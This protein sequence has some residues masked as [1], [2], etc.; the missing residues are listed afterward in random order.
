MEH[1]GTPAWRSRMVRPC[2]ATGWPSTCAGPI[3][4]WR[5]A[6]R[7]M[8][9]SSCCSTSRLARWTAARPGTKHS[10]SAARL[11]DLE[12][13]LEDASDSVRVSFDAEALARAIDPDIEAHGLREKMA[14]LAI[15]VATTGAAAGS[16]QAMPSLGGQGG[17]SGDATVTSARD[18]PAD[19]LERVGRVHRGRSR[20]PGKPERC[21]QRRRIAPEDGGALGGAGRL[22]SYRDVLPSGHHAAPAGGDR[23]VPRPAVRFGPGIPGAAARTWRGWRGC[24][25]LELGR[26][27]DLRRSR[28]DR[29]GA[30]R[31]GLRSCSGHAQHPQADLSSP[32]RIWWRPGTRPPPSVFDLRFRRHPRARSAA[33]TVGWIRLPDWRAVRDSGEVSESPREALRANA[34]CPVPSTRTTSMLLLG[35]RNLP[36]RASRTANAARR[37]TAGVPPRSRRDGSPAPSLIGQPWWSKH[38]PWSRPP[39]GRG[40]APTS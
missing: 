14:V 17:G 25:R 34:V 37:G 5:S 12:R 27:L 38:K 40:I 16:A 36:L 22:D 7:T 2:L 13:M 23:P 18:M 30:P 10:R 26:L 21:Q 28:R 8:E 35:T 19:S 1:Q 9:W 29:A 3:S 20:H 33:V 6:P 31:R 39:A 15:V 32:Q 24:D 4:R 11:A